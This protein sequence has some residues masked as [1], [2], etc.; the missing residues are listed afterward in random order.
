MHSASWDILCKESL[1]VKERILSF[2]GY[3]AFFVD[4]T[5]IVMRLTILCNMQ[6]LASDDSCVIPSY[7]LV[8][9]LI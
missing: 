2:N 3:D 7:N 1:N 5:E 9:H 4:I 6:I 8:H